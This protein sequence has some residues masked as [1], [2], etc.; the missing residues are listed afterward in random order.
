MLVKLFFNFFFNVGRSNVGGLVRAVDEGA[1]IP[2][3]VADI[4]AIYLLVKLF[5]KFFTR[6][7]TGR[8]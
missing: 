1:F 2:V 4:L 5:F 7:L 3:D 6:P 8:P